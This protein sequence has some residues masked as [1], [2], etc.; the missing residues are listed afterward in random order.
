MSLLINSLKRKIDNCDLK[1]SKIVKKIGE[2]GVDVDSGAE[3]LF[4]N[5]F[6]SKIE[7][8]F[9]KDIGKGSI[10]RGEY[11]H[12]TINNTWNGN[13]SVILSAKNKNKTKVFLESKNIYSYQIEQISKNILDG[14]QTVTY[15]GMSLD[16]TLLN[17]K[18][19]DEW[20]NA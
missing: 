11:G 14:R 12:I 8:S 3:I 9:K 4:K 18:I 19:I 17:M 16:E 1:L 6:K 20:L 13:D 5:G 2:T 15:P 10:I 7:A